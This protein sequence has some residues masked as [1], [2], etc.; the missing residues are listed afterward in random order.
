M[1]YLL[2]LAYSITLNRLYKDPCDIFKTLS[3]Q[4]MSVVLERSIFIGDYLNN[5]IAISQLTII[6]KIRG[7]PTGRHAV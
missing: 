6:T 1:F 2:Y 5:G 4:L 3:A 7:S